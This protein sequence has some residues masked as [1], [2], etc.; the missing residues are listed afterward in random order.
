MPNQVTKMAMIGGITKPPRAPNPPTIPAEPPKVCDEKNNGEEGKEAKPNH[1]GCGEAQV[2]PQEGQEQSKEAGSHVA[3]SGI[4][5][6]GG[7]LLSLGVPVRYGGNSHG[8]NGN[9][10]T[11][12]DSEEEEQR[13]LRGTWRPEGAEKEGDAINSQGRKG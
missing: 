11:G 9:P 7:S 5:C 3:Q 13:I 10:A 12:K 4:A 1:I 2:F 8:K 6:K